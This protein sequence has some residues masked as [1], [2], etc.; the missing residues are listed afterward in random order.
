MSLPDYMVAA[1]SARPLGISI[2]SVLHFL[3]GVV[4]LILAAAFPILTANKPEIAEGMAAVG[5]PLPLLIAGIVFLAVLAIGS[6]IGMWIGA[7]W[8][9]YLGSFYYMYSVVRNILAFLNVYLLVDQMPAAEVA[10][11]TRG[12]EYHYFKFGG[13]VVIHALIFLYFFKG[14][15]VE[16]FG[17]K[18]TSGWKVLLI[19]FGICV[20][21]V[22]AISL[23]SSVSQ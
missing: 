8:G 11:M 23:W 4:L 2:L 14:N 10:A 9:W 12:P 20:G 6:G 3:G 16:H 19:E 5:I 7:K 15:V 13:R 18:D 21:I 1:R 17:L 22:A